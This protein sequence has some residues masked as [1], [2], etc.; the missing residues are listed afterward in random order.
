MGNL[1][2][3]LLHD[4]KGVE[5]TVMKI[6]VGIIL[7]SIGLGIGVTVYRRFGEEIT[8]GVYTMEVIPNQKSGSP[9]EKLSGIS[10]SVS[11]T[12]KDGEN[13]TLEATGDYPATVRFN[14]TEEYTTELPVNA[15]MTVDIDNGASPGEEYA[16]TINAVKTGTGKSVADKSFTLTIE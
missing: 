14:G 15:S 11:K 4:Q 9:G 10:V 8:G 3:S 2:R 5:P 16:I 7:V 6:L 1:R 13:I 12:P